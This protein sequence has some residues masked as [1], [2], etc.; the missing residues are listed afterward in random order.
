MDEGIE[1]MDT[2]MQQTPKKKSVE[3]FKEKPKEL[4]PL[5][6]LGSPDEKKPLSKPLRDDLRRPVPKPFSKPVSKKPLPYLGDP[7]KEKR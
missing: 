2:P 4:A 7:E 6:G 3:K 5:P 1:R